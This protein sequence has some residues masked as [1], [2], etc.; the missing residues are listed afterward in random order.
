MTKQKETRRSANQPSRQKQDELRARHIDRCVT[1]FVREMMQEHPRLLTA[2]LCVMQS[3]ADAGAAVHYRVAFSPRE[4]FDPKTIDYGQP[5]EAWDDASYVREFYRC[6]YSSGE[7]SWYNNDD[8]I[9][10]F[11]AFCKE[12]WRYRQ[13]A[14]FRREISETEAGL[15]EAALHDPQAREV[16][17]DYWEARGVS[18]T[19]TIKVVGQMLRPHL[20]GVRRAWF[21]APGDEK[22]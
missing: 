16:L 21:R 1:P 7:D 12:D 8:A 13:Y 17:G 18:Q 3:G 10:L 9:P 2:T 11:A 5:D 19:L 14:V 22:S 4:A 6:A 20:D 15:R